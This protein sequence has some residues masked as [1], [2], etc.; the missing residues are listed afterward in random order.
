MTMNVG[1]KS[2]AWRAKFPPTMD[3]GTAQI[4]AAEQ[5]RDK[6]AADLQAS[7]WARPIDP[8][9]VT[10][11]ARKFKE[12]AQLLMRLHLELRARRTWTR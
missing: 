7:L 8:V 9:D 5:A 3:A 6:A 1:G 10:A 2:P 11:S 12:S 4:H